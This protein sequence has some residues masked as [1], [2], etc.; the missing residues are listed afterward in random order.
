[1]VKPQISFSDINYSRSLNIKNVGQQVEN[2]IKSAQE[3]TNL[4][5]KLKILEN[6]IT[7][8]YAIESILIPEPDNHKFPIWV[9]E[10]NTILEEPSPEGRRQVVLSLS[11]KSPIYSLIVQTIFSN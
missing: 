10:F 5:K 8:L 1:M 11:D 3:A 4:S 2:L 9:S 7:D 6:L